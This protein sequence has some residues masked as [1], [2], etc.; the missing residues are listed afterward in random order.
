MG[1]SKKMLTNWLEK[2]VNRYINHLVQASLS[3][4]TEDIVNEARKSGILYFSHYVA[5][6]LH[7]IVRK[8]TPSSDNQDFALSTWFVSQFDDIKKHFPD[9]V[10]ITSKGGILQ[11]S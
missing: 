8:I 10:V 3:N 4:K 9:A 6:E 1:A 11:A 5:E 7:Y 2:I